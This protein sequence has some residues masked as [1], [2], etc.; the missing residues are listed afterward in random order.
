MTGAYLAAAAVL[1][2]LAG[3]R[4]GWEIFP[5]VDSGQFQLRLRAADGTRIETAEE[6]TL[7]ALAIIE[8]EAGA[9]KVAISAG[10]VGLIPTAYPISAVHQW[11]RGPE[12]SF[13][14]VVLRRGSGLNVSDFKERLRAELPRRLGI[15]LRRKLL[16]NGLTAD[17]VDAQVRQLRLSFEPGDIINTVMSF[18]S[19][20]PVEVAVSGRK[21]EDNRAYAAKV[22]D[23][24]ARVKSLRDLQ[25]AQRWT[26]QRSMCAWTASGPDSAASPP[27]MS[28]VRWS[29]PPRPAAS[30]CSTSG[31]I[32]T[33][34][35]ATRCRWKCRPFRWTRPAPS[36]WCPSRARATNICC[37]AT[38]PRSAR[39]R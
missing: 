5:S 23:Q 29:P 10:Y 15:W 22:F 26:I 36:A 30:S 24:L 27:P 34:A 6:I 39:G 1:I 9:D 37:C 18:G 11:M 21:M 35:S 38:W 33:P 4:L 28:A 8:E 31:P 32:P 17:K 14:R 3:G 13:L 7:Q 19:P 2:W 20:T 25:I 16:A 12:E